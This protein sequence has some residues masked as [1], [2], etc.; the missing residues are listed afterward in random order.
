FLATGEG[1]YTIPPTPLKGRHG[2]AFRFQYMVVSGDDMLR[3]AAEA[4][5]RLQASRE[6]RDLTSP[7]APKTI[8]PVMTP[9]KGHIGPQMLSGLLGTNRVTSPD[10]RRPLLLKGHIQKRRYA[11]RGEALDLVNDD[12]PADDKKR[13]LKRVEI[14][15]KFEAVMMTLHA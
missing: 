12:L 15:E 10:D 5:A 1:Q 2:A 14:K 3:E 8:T 9:K 13:H 7:T 11:V 4:A 6:W